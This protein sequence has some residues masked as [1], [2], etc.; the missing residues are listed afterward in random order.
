MGK[1]VTVV[2]GEMDVTGRNLNP[3]KEEATRANSNSD[4]SLQP[5]AA[6]NFQ[7]ARSASFPVDDVHQAW[8]M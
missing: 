8:I 3:G 7:E 1:G 4:A 6:A 2:P 5:A